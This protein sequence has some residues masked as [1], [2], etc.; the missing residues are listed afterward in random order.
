[1]TPPRQ[2]DVLTI[3][4]QDEGKGMSPARL[5]EIQSRGSGVGILGMRE[6]LRQ[7]HGDMKIKSGPTG[8][9]VRVTIPI[10]RQSQTE[11]QESANPCLPSNN[12]IERGLNPNCRLGAAR[13]ST[14]TGI[15]D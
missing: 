1:M 12:P 2:Q 15:C 13:P 10:P 7:F 14:Q 5:A 11:E 3:N 9:H 6:R 4:I 8:T